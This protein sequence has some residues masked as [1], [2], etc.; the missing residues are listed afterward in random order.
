[1][2]CSKL[3]T[4]NI[5]RSEEV[6]SVVF[7][8]DEIFTSLDIVSMA[9]IDLQEKSKLERSVHFAF[10]NKRIGLNVR[11]IFYYSVYFD[12]KFCNKVGAISLFN[13]FVK[14]PPHA[15]FICMYNNVMIV[16]L[17]VDLCVQMTQIGQAQNK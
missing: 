13:I 4:I 9:R 16:F 2:A 10:E 6:C 3:T 14:S 12:I 1:L 8:Q 5:H 15:Q 11:G 7:R 17:Y